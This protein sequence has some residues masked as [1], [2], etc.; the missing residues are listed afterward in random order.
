MYNF[1]DFILSDR[2]GRQKQNGWG[3]TPDG[4]NGCT[5]KQWHV[6]KN[7]NKT[8]WT[9]KLLRQKFSLEF[10]EKEKKN[11]WQLIYFLN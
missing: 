3:S 7:K 1:V 2:D 9:K 4:Q 11:V 6:K 8:T 10:H 5:L